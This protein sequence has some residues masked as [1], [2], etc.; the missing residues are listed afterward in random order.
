M[1]EAFN[2]E[3]HITWQQVEIIRGYKYAMLGVK[4]RDI[5]IRSGRGIGKT[6]CMSWLILH[7]LF[8]YP[9]CKIPCTAP[10]ADQMYDV[11]WAEVALW[12]GKMPKFIANMYEW[13][14]DH[15][16]MKESPDNWFARAK[17]ATKE[18]PEAL[19]GIHADYIM[20]VIDEASAVPDPIFDNAEATLTNPDYV[21]IMISNPT[22]MMGRFYES[23]KKLKGHYQTM[24]F[25]SEESPVVDTEKIKKIIDKYGMAS[26]QYLVEVL[27]EF[28]TS[29]SVDEKGYMPLINFPILVC[30]DYNFIGEMIMGCDPA[31]DGGDTTEI[32]IRDH[33]KAWTMAT[34]LKSNPKS[35]AN[36][37]ATVLLTNPCKDKVIDNF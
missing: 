37:M 11:L 29:D 14:K 24:Q 10:T 12:L 23:H 17:T 13:S 16:R 30:D 20:Q 15:I 1:F 22:R 35:V 25:S 3:I 21:T 33:A 27:G 36:L 4:P 8:V 28:P 31:G 32:I 18:N 6:A 19:S 2:K 26:S 9:M 7:F 34:E 5:S